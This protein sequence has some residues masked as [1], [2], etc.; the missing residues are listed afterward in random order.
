MST[1][2]PLIL[3]AVFRRNMQVMTAICKR[4]SAEKKREARSV[5]L[6]VHQSVLSTA[7]YTHPIDSSVEMRQEEFS[8][9]RDVYSFACQTQKCR[10]V[11][12]GA[13]GKSRVLFLQR[14]QGFD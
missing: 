2:K 13:S 10:A 8:L 9:Q 11:H 6:Q 3:T 5:V 7:S 12:H 14:H 4:L 1:A